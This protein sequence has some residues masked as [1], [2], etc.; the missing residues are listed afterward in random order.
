MNETATLQI[1]DALG[2]KLKEQKIM[3]NDNSSFSVDIKD[4]AKGVYHLL[5]QGSIGVRQQK[6]LNL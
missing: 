3:R 1:T 6:S 4:L 5:L 2:R